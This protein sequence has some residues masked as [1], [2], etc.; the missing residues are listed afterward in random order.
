MPLFLTFKTSLKITKFSNALHFSFHSYNFLSTANTYKLAAPGV[1]I[2]FTVR[3]HT[4]NANARD[5][6]KTA[7]EYAQYD[8]EHNH[9]ANVAVIIALLP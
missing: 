2:H 3:A 5:E 1:Q 7:F 9:M 8:P 6:F 4:K